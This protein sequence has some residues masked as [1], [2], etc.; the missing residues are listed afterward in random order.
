MTMDIKP[1]CMF[2]SDFEN[3]K[4]NFV[5]LRITPKYVFNHSKLI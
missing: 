1:K 2:E 5:M 4:I 3:V